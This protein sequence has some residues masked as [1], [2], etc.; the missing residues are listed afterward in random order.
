MMNKCKKNVHSFSQTSEKF[1][2]V[3]G[4][5]S[6]NAERGTD[7]FFLCETTKSA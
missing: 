6:E 3:F 4:S 1:T 2:R 5:W 7:F